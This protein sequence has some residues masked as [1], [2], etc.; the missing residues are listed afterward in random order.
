[1]GPPTVDFRFGAFELRPR[2][3][4]LFKHGVKI[5]LRPQPLRVL[6]ILLESS[7][8]VVTREE[9]RKQ[10]WTSETFVDFEHGLNTSVK[11][12]RGVLGDSATK[13]HYIQTLPRVGYRMMV[14]VAVE[15]PPGAPGLPSASQA[16]TP[17][18]RA[19]QWVSPRNA[20]GMRAARRWRIFAVVSIVVI[21]AAAA[22]VAWSFSRSRVR[23]SSGRVMLAVLPFENLTGD[24]SQDYFSDGLTEEM[25]NQ[26]GRFE[27]QR[28]GVIARASVMHYKRSQEQLDR[29]GRELG[30]QYV[31]E[32]SVRRDVDKVRISAELIQLKDQ[33]HLW[34]RQ[35]DRELSSLLTLQ[36]EI[37]QEI[38][39]EIQLTLGAPK[40]VT[41]T[42]RPALSPQAFE[43]YDL[44]LKGQYF[45]NKRTVQG[46]RQAIEYFQQAIA[47]D[48]GNA[49]AY[50]GLADSYALMG[51]YSLAPQTESMPK[52]RVAALRALQLDDTLAEAHTA[53]AL[54]VQNY[55]WDWQTSEKEFRRAIE[56][57]P[58]YAT[59]HHWYAEHLTWLGR[60]DEAF[61]ESERARQ[62]DPLSLIIAT[63]KGAILYFSR[64]YDRAIAQFGSVR[65]LE[66]NFPRTGMVINAYVEK[67]SFADAVN[68]IEKGRRAVGDEP[69]HWS[70]MA[71]VYG[72]SGQRA[73]AR[74]ALVKLEQLSRHQ[75]IDPTAFFWAHL[76][77]DNKDETFAWLEKA[78]SQHSN[79]LTTLKVEPAFDPLRHDPRFG[80]LLRRV[81]LAP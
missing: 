39:D 43:A 79:V 66:P 27:P 7:G 12:L 61:Q 75:P 15:S 14:P 73:R 52:A 11:E 38:A 25:I 77:M 24:A 34:A 6:Q 80:A 28:L 60:F 51:G 45:W 54:I 68:D 63:D 5:R 22:Y 67:G 20:Q 42:G 9:L 47:K 32:G 30:V 81:G 35:Y 74:R 31:L 36:S 53:L 44:Y 3:Q 2:S 26:L 48:A 1:L 40:P 78:R 21:A 59:A 17:E 71:Y 18:M 10:L 16:A 49:R 8:E 19:E 37:A 57:N 4:E 58:N 55:D 62:L 33:T 29:I 56:L 64:Q 76:G 23:L 50:A 69:W 70:A 72:R 46:F 13:P 65:E 41:P